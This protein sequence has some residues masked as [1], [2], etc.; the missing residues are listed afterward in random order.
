MVTRLTLLPAGG[1]PFSGRPGGVRES[2][3]AKPAP[4]AE[5]K[6]AKSAA[7]ASAGRGVTESG[8]Q[9]SATP[10]PAP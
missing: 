6:N 10:L 2:V 3:G 7:P 5:K 8:C 9:V 1:A 4:F